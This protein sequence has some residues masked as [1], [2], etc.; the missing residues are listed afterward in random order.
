MKP[1]KMT[2]SRAKALTAP[3]LH[4]DR[5][6]G[7]ASNLYLQVT[8]SRLPGGDHPP[9]RS[10]IYRY[11]SPI[12]RRARQMGLGSVIHITL[13]EARELARQY[14][15]MIRLERID[16]IDQR[17]G[18]LTAARVEAVK[19]ITF[20]EVVRKYLDSR[21]AGQNTKHMRQVEVSLTTETASINHVPVS[22]IDTALILRVL[23]PRWKER[24]ATMQRT[25]SRIE[26]VL[27]YAGVA[28]YRTG[29]NPARWKG[30][31]E[32]V[33]K[34]PAGNGVEKHHA[35]LPVEQLPSFMT[36]LRANPSRTARLLEYLILTAARSKEGRCAR[37]DTINLE[38]AT[39]TIPAS[40]MKARRPHVVP[41]S[42]R[43]MEILAGLPRNGVYVFSGSSPDKPL[44]ESAL[45][46]F[47]VGVT[48]HGFRSTFK[49][50]CDSRGFA[51]D[52]SERALAHKDKDKTRDAYK[53]ADRL[54]ARRPMMQQWSDYC[55]RAPAANVIP[56]KGAAA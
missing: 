32:H 19:T 37:W 9:A 10:W 40:E 15:K 46:S 54:E 27:D 6:D 34:A 5:G 20:S 2:D 13:A 16:P 18:A 41:L 4:R 35:A 43:C 1:I 52:V 48:K 3:G 30:H 44:S 42:S 53:R 28:G 21:P 29:D 50:W 23:Q 26:S 47:D 17:K 38:T 36:Q 33:L 11:K 7:A 39:W 22:D 51:D 49:D 12:H 25:R 45:D 56:I 8:P 24:T 55:S 31:L 14:S